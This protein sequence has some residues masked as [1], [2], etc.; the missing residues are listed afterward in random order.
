MSRDFQNFEDIQKLFVQTLREMLSAVKY[1]C[2]VER[3]V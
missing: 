2:H 3:D 1:V